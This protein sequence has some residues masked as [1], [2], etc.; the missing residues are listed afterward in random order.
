V[1]DLLTTIDASQVNFDIV[2]HFLTFLAHYP[3][4]VLRYGSF[5][6]AACSVLC[7]SA[8][9]AHRSCAEVDEL[10]AVTLGGRII[11]A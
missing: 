5:L 6:P 3:H 4:T 7:V 2:S 11:W 1:T 9:W 8:C 10:I